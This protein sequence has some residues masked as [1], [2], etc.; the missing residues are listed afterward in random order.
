MS[1]PARATRSRARACRGL[2]AL[3]RTFSR[4][5]ISAAIF[6]NTPGM[7]R[8]LPGQVG[9][10]WGQESQTASWRSHSA[11]MRKPSAAGAWTGG[12]MGLLVP[13]TPRQV[14]VG[15]NSAVPQKG[16]VGSRGVNRR[17]VNLGEE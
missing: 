1:A 4:R 8:K 3:I 12:G 16:P 11:G 14:A 15:V 6:A 10:L 5:L 2:A 13:E 9:R 7:G 17:Q